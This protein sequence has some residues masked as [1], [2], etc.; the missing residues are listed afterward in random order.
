MCVRV[1]K[2]SLPSDAQKALTRAERLEVLRK[3]LH[4]PPGELILIEKRLEEATTP[5][6]PPHT[7][8]DPLIAFSHRVTQLKFIILEIGLL[9]VFLVSVYTVIKHELR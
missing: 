3:A 8:E 7:P 5:Q 9:I 2:R 1:A 6:S 4:L